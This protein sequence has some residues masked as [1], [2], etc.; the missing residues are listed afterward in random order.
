MSAL[1]WWLTVTLPLAVVALVLALA[2]RSALRTAR[3]NDEAADE[4]ARLR[5]RYRAEVA[6]LANRIVTARCGLTA[7][8]ALTP[9]ALPDEWAD[10]LL[11]TEG[12]QR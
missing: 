6:A 2:L 12:S 7:M 4:A 1:V 10:G 5:V 9:D 8:A 11:A 3:L